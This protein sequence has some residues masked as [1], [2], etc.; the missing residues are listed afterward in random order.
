MACM[1]DGILDLPGDVG[2][3]G[4]VWP[5]AGDCADCAIFEDYRVAIMERVRL[6]EEETNRSYEYFLYLSLL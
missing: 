1:A 5:V 2:L 6:F 3:L 4:E